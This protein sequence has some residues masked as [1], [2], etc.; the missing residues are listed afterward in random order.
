VKK[1]FVIGLLALASIAHAQ[2]QIPTSQ[3]SGAVLRGLDTM[4][5]LTKDINIDVGQVE[6]YERLEISLAECRYPTENPA[7]DAFA[8]LTIRDIREDIPRFKGWMIASSPAL[9]AL[10][11]PRYDIWVLRCKIPAAVTS[12]G[13]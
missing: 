10:D 4:T 3:S 7:T 5:G 13:G 1:F 11:H 12:N 2:V 9:S 6:I 8:Y